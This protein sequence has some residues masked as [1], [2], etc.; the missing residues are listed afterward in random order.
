MT[1]N[2]TLSSKGVTMQPFPSKIPLTRATYRLET[3]RFSK[4]S[5]CGEKD[6]SRNQSLLEF[7]ADRISTRKS[8]YMYTYLY[9]HHIYS[10]GKDQPGKVANP[11]RGQLIADG[12]QRYHPDCGHLRIFPSLP[13]SRLTIFYHDVSSALLQLVDQWLDFYLLTFPRFPLWKKEHK[14]WFDKNRTRD[15]RTCRCAGYLLDHLSDE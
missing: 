2:I 8:A 14:F 6:G 5:L 12:P 13:G 9:G 11:A 15:F 1:N 7:S 3:S 10:K 4:A